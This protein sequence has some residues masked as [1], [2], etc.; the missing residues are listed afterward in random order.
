M[1]MH[2]M[3]EAATQRETELIESRA[4]ALEHEAENL[5]K[6]LKISRDYGSL[7]VDDIYL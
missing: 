6:M 1:M 3:R 7:N 2:A 4:P 5:R